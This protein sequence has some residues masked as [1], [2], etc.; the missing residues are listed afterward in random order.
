MSTGTGAAKDGR[1]A[2]LCE[3]RKVRQQDRLNHS[4]LNQVQGGKKVIL[5]NLWLPSRE[6]ASGL[7]GSLFATYSPDGFLPR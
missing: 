6:I 7:A 1:T 3:Q 5:V 4:Y 2:Q